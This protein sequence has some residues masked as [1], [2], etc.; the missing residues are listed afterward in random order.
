MKHHKLPVCWILGGVLAALGAG[1]LWYNAST[2]ASEEKRLVRKQEALNTLR[3]LQIQAQQDEAA[4]Y[5]YKAL[6]VRTRQPL[7]S[8]RTGLEQQGTVQWTRVGTEPVMDAW[9]RET[10][11]IAVTNID[12]TLLSDFFYQAAALRPPWILETIDLAPGQTPG[13]GDVTLTMQSIYENP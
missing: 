5:G 2:A 9:V 8:L 6:P 1:L 13:V 10:V 3:T 7:E 11:R 12:F 4:Q